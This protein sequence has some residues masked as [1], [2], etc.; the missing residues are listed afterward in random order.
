MGSIKPEAMIASTCN[1]LVGGLIEKG[2]AILVN[3]I[4][5]NYPFLQLKNRDRGICWELREFTG[6]SFGAFSLSYITEQEN[7]A[8]AAWQGQNKTSTDLF[9]FCLGAFS[10]V[11]GT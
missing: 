8:Y 11:P 2:F 6:A 5:Y 9:I 4:Y 10:K 1:C 3:V 7:V